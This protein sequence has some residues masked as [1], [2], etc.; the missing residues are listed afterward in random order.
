[1]A[2]TI[3]TYVI[4]YGRER[5]GVDISVIQVN[6][7]NLLI[8]AQVVERLFHVQSVPAIEFKNKDDCQMY[9]IV[10]NSKKS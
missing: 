8:S 6:E 7:I 5:M 2:D 1:M 3:F 4:N 9:D 10:F